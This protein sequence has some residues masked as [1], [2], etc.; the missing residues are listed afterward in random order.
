MF[1]Q[2]L[3]GCREERT[4]SSINSASSH[5][6]DDDGSTPS[7][8]PSSNSSEKQT[9]GKMGMAKSIQSQGCQ[10]Q[11]PPRIPPLGLLAF[12]M[13]PVSILNV[14]LERCSK[15]GPWHPVDTKAGTRKGGN[16]RELSF[17]L[18]QNQVPPKTLQDSER[19]KDS[20]KLHCKP[21]QTHLSVFWAPRSH[22]SGRA[23]QWVLPAI[24]KGIVCRS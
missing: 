11:S 5:P 6:W 17:D 13:R 15:C 23:G 12:E 21:C 19:C 24:R 14:L 20:P 4:P 9:P 10:R 7:Y 22:G 18:A 3:G 16:R 2:E 8:M 1:S